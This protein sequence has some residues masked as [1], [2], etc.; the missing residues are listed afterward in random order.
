MAAEIFD[1]NDESIA[2]AVKNLGCGALVGMPTE[3][4]YGL[5]A[6]ATNEKAV[7]EIF[8]AKNRPEFNPLIVHVSGADMAKKY[9]IWNDRA[10]KLAAKFWP[11]PLTMVLPRCADSAVSFLAT[12]GLDSIAI[13]SPKHPVARK[14]IM[15][16]DRGI[17]APSANRS[18]RISPTTAQH[19]KEELGD[20][21]S[22]IIDGGP[23]SVGIESTV[24]SLL[25]DKPALLRAGSVT[26]EEIEAALGE[27]IEQGGDEKILSPGQMLSHYAPGIP[28]RLNAMN[29]KNDEAYIAFGNKIPFGAKKTM[30]LSNRG[31]LKEAAANL[32]AT[33]RALDS[34]E[35][36]GIAVMPI[37]EKD[38]GVAINDRLRRAA[39]G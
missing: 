15:A 18:G 33:M 7:A 26:K 31:D 35:F 22:C 24:L 32:F 8:A 16:L 39:H 36:S 3:T 30:N 4:V 34:K 13:R 9:V 5:A 23:C 1:T 38:I 6:D 29:P 28:I 19:V 20:A 11:G 37:P 14:I 10:E 25:G 2:R 21:I 12:A 27:T 17:A